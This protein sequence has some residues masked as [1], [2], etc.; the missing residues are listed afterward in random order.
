MTTQEIFS[1]NLKEIMYRKGYNQSD[2][3][4]HLGV[5]H[6]TVSDWVNGKSIP[7]GNMNALCKFL[8]TDVFKLLSEGENL[9]YKLLHDFRMLSPTGKQKAIERMEELTKLYWYEKGE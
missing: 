4:N 6:S 9:E 7:H 5:A 1:K 8:G 3:V 2:I